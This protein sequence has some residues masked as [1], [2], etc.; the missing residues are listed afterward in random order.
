MAMTSR[1]RIRDF[2]VF[3]QAP[4]RSLILEGLGEHWGVV[5]PALNSDL[6]D[7]HASYG[8]GRTIVAT[9]GTAIVGTGTVVVSDVNTAE[10]VRMSVAHD[11][12]R[13]GLGR[14]IL[15]E[16]VVTA[17]AWGCG[18]VVLETSSHWA[19]VVTSYL[20]CGFTITHESD[21]EFGPDTWFELRLH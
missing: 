18:R 6:D 4:V 17:Y 1:V 13:L 11:V 14:A 10:V 15:D 7:I 19:E 8:H 5:D 16:L 3:D 20:R 12:R 21:G 9:L 2:D